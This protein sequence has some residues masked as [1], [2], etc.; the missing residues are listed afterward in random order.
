MKWGKAD[1][2]S[3]L[4]LDRRREYSGPGI[5]DVSVKSAVLPWG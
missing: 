2:W 4:I 1:M 3:L 5:N